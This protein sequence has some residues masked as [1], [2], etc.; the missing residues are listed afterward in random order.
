[1][2]V[3]TSQ[4]T[5]FANSGLLIYFFIPL[6]AKNEAFCEVRVTSHQMSRKHG[7]YSPSPSLRASAGLRFLFLRY[8]P[9]A[10]PL[11]IICRKNVPASLLPFSLF[12][13]NSKV[14]GLLTR[15][16]VNFVGL[17]RFALN[18]RSRNIYCFIK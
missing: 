15:L 9:S 11:Q 7:G 18:L 4:N 14:K 1:M 16:L 12:L 8:V 3:L 6:F 5:R 10:A 2:E 13:Q 17:S